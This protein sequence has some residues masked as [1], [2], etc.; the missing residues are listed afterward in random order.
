MEFRHCVAN[1]TLSCID[2]A[3]VLSFSS[4][5]SSFFDFYCLP[6]FPTVTFSY[7]SS[8]SDLFHHSSYHIPYLTHYS[9][10][11]SFLANCPFHYAM[12]YPFHLPMSYH[13]QLPTRKPP[14]CLSS[15]AY[16]LFISLPT[17]YNALKESTFFSQFASLLTVFDASPYS[18]FSSK[19]RGWG[20]TAAS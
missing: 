2:S 19:V 15:Y 4:F 9:F 16:S 20:S 10:S 17:G 14:T 11:P 6:S 18:I 5:L 8:R 1:G 7:I 3:F 13:A 12:N